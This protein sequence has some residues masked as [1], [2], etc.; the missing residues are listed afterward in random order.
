[1]EVRAISLDILGYLIQNKGEVQSLISDL[2]ILDLSLKNIKEYP[3]SLVN[4]DVVIHSLEIVSCLVQGKGEEVHKI[5][6]KGGLSSLI[7]QL[8]MMLKHS[9]IEESEAKKA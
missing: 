8:G 5:I 1:L 7:M 6:A 2:G 3:S 9:R 4:Q